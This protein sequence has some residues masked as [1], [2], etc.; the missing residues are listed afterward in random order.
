MLNKQD[1][2]FKTVHETMKKNGINDSHI[3]SLRNK[4]VSFKKS[5]FKK[6]GIF[7]SD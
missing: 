3:E 4:Q 7:E 5:E 1:R 2:I 6:A